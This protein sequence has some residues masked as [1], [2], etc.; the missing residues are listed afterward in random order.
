MLTIT[1]LKEFTKKFQTSETNIIREYI[2]H[3]CLLNLY[4][5]KEA[6]NLLFK[7]GT[8]LRFIFRS[9]RFSEDLDFTGYFYHRKEID[10]LLLKTL[11][12]I[13][14][15]GIEIN[16]KE[17]KITSGGY[18]GIIRYRLMD[19]VGEMHLEISLR[20]YKKNKGEVATVINDFIPSYTLV[21][22]SSADLVAEKI[23]ALITRAKSRDYYDLYFQLRHPAL[24]KF[25]DK[26]RLNKVL[27][28]LESETIDFRRE[29]AVL[30]PVSHHM[31]LRN[32][33][34]LL[35]KEIAQYF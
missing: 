10:E 26:N 29:L 32:F 12:E 31:I 18:L 22:L 1:E 30:L 21:Y 19:Y 17:A 11:S 3:L 9:P 15:T 24:N 34:E 28:L 13:E 4:R 5:H 27:K 20:K 14:R 33:K 23:Q 6:D 7:G 2:Q 35:K 25:V 16:I 8:A